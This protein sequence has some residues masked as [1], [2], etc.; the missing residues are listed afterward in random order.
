MS[1]DLYIHVLTPPCTEDDLAVFNSNTMGSKWFNPRPVSDWEGE[2]PVY[3]RVGGTPKI[4]IGE[5]SWLKAGLFEN[6][7]KYVPDAVAAITDLIGEDLPVLDDELAKKILGTFDAP[8]RTNYSLSGASAEL[9]GFLEQWRGQR[10]FCV[11]W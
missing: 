4:W 7:D 11:S 9:R 2:Q 3:E 1:A 8:N 10:L 5:V 6:P